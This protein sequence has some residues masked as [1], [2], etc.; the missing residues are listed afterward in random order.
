MGSSLGPVLANIVMTELE[1]HVIKPFIDNG[2]I[3]FYCRYVDDTLVLVKPDDID[4]IHNALNNFHPNLKFTI[5][6]FEDTDTHFLD[7][8]ILNTLDIDIY[9]KD[10]FSGQ[11][12]DYNSFIP[13]HFKASWIRSLFIDVKLSV[14]MIHYLKNKPY[15]FQN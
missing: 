14:L 8:L 2:I 9:R 3:K 11:Y 7:L 1:K 15:L 4:M 13:W 12:I 10:T 6:N 5:D